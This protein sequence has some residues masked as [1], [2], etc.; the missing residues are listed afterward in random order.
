MSPKRKVLP[1]VGRH[2]VAILA[3]LG[4]GAAEISALRAVGAV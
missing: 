3:E 2:S 1:A 4:Y